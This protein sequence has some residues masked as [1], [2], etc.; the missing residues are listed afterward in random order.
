MQYFYYNCIFYSAPNACN[1]IYLL[2]YN[3]VK[4]ETRKVKEETDQID[5]EKEQICLQILEKQRKFAYYES[6]SDTL[7]KVQRFCLCTYGRI[8][9]WGH[10]HSVVLKEPKHDFSI[11]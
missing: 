4:N 6:D 8:M 3:A 7:C 9:H 1:F 2:K 5:R 10:V 11:F